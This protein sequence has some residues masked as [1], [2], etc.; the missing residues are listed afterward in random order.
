MFNVIDHQSGFKI[1]FIVRKDT[2]YRRLE[3]SRKTLKVLDDIPVWIVS[4]EDLIVSKIEWIQQLQSD[5]QI[6][7]IKMLMRLPEIDIDYIISW[8]NKLNFKTFDLL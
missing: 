2:E 8:C 4:A 6:Q 5:R 1:D 3:F 7:D